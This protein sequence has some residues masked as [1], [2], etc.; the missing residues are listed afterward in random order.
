MSQQIVSEKYTAIL[1]TGHDL[2][3]K[4]GIRRVTIE[5]ICREAGVSKMTFYRFF[6]N[7]T[8]LAKKVL[9]NTYEEMQRDY[10]RLMDQDIPFEDKI[11]QQLIM[12][13]EGTKEISPELLKEFYGD[14]DSEIVTFWKSY[15]DQM[16]RMVFDDY[17]KAQKRGW[18]RKDIN[19]NFIFYIFNKSIEIASDKNL[20]SSYP[21]LQALIMEIANFFFYGVLPHPDKQ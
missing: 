6:P 17:A 5:E 2:F 16:I 15:A 14:P 13:F 3:W 7:K 18:I 20:Q 10:R 19:L 1:K 4:F 21:N 8:E 12:K 9:Q 11:K